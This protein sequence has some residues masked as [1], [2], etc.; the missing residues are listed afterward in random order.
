MDGTIKY[1]PSEVTQTQKGKGH[2]WYILTNK[3]MLEKK[4]QNTF[5]DHRT[6]KSQQAEVPK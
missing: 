2:A 1:H 3:W 6:Q 4:V 5:T